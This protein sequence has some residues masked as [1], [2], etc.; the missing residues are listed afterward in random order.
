[1]TSPAGDL[2][3][4]G[5]TLA[6]QYA[7]EREL[8]RGGMGVVYLARELKLERRVALKVLPQALCGDADLR[9]R[10]LREARTAAQLQHPGVVPIY[11]ADELAG[12]AFFTMAYVEGETLAQRIR[13]AGPLPPTDAVRILREVARALAYAHARGVVHRDIKPENILLDAATG[14]A[15]VTD[16]GIAKSASASTLTADGH[17]LG[18]VF[19]MSPEQ[20]NGEPLDGRSDLYALGVVGY[21]AL[22]GRLPFDGTSTAV[23]VAH[24]TR[25]APPLATVAPGLPAG[26]CAVIDRCLAKDRAA[27]FATGDELAAALAEGLATPAPLPLPPR[28]VDDAAAESLWRR[29][30]EIQAEASGIARRPALPVGPPADALRTA[31]TPGEGYRLADVR[32]AAKA[33]GIEP[34]FVALAV[35]EADAHQRP[36]PP[37]SPRA[38][39]LAKA[40]FGDL[41]T[42]LVVQR[43][44]RASP[45]AVLAAVGRTFTAYPFDLEVRDTIGGHPLD[46]GILVFEVPRWSSMEMNAQ[47]EVMYFRYYLQNLGARRL[48]VRLR[49]VPGEA[50]ACEVTVVADIRRGVRSTVRG[51]PLAFA[52]GTTG[53]ACGS[54]A[55]GL[56]LGVAGVPLAALSIAGGAVLGSVVGGTVALAA[57]WSR[58][59]ARQHVRRL[60][61][62]LE[63]SLRNFALF[64]SLEPPRRP[65]PRNTGGDFIPIVS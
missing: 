12:C 53:G 64:G 47:P 40:I 36:V 17:V 46:G 38:E 1:M 37:L 44:L 45:S 65:P 33:V 54:T 22:A 51:F 62:A 52:G 7:L 34:E 56:A 20:V 61:D 58:Y 55:I 18:T 5:G 9:E 50:G 41:R 11:R 3:Y 29:A 35:A 4:Y 59:K 43:T 48:L 2:E 26:L 32:D 25:P 63:V 24:A 30:A 10:F 16:F 42:T 21:Y 6:G 8:G 28:V 13:R 39:R 27:R 14:A 15:V 57:R 60:L 23:L 31:R 49:P 19:Y